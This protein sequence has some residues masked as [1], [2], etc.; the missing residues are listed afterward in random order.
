M[1]VGAESC[2]E[3]GAG[4]CAIDPRTGRCIPTL[5]SSQAAVGAHLIVATSGLAC[6]PPCHR[7]PP[8]PRAH[9]ASLAGDQ[10]MRQTNCPAYLCR[11]PQRGRP[12]IAQRIHPWGTM[13]IV[14]TESWKDGRRA[15][16]DCP[17]V[18]TG[19][20]FGRRNGTPGMNPLG[21]C[22]PSL[23]GTRAVSVTRASACTSP[24]LYKTR[25]HMPQHG[26]IITNDVGGCQRRL[27]SP[28]RADVVRRARR[29][30]KLGSGNR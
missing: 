13:S 11:S 15:D 26:A 24:P 25:L 9:P 27:T 17:F 18:P 4:P 19:L 23:P 2:T 10:S 14:M 12:T 21:Y 16:S 8:P 22:R 30:G 5:S 29:P 20:G 7:P 1:S 28:G 3:P 6:S